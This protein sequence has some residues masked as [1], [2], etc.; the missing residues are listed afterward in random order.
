MTNIFNQLLTPHF[1]V[2]NITYCDS[3]TPFQLSFQ[4]LSTPIMR[5]IIDFHN[6]LMLFIVF[7]VFFV[8]YLLLYCFNKYGEG[9]NSKPADPFTQSTVLE[10]IWTV[11]P[12]LILVVVAT[13]SFALLY[14]MD[15]MIDPSLTV[16][17]IGHQWY[18]SYEYSNSYSDPV[19][20]EEKYVSL[21]FDSFM[22]PFEELFIAPLSDRL[23]DNSKQFRNLEV[24][25]KLF[26]PAHT[27]IRLLV[28]SADVLHSWTIPS[29]GIK[30][31]G[32][33][34]WIKSSPTSFI[35]VW[36]LFWS[37][38]RNLRYKPWFYAHTLY[39]R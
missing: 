8:T 38:F 10:V 23:D 29:F 22:V 39:V 37:M 17:I 14:S 28:S 5:G 25:K 2:R 33:S 34:W 16:K 13:P 9:S 36:Y 6:H 32:L 26:L 3:P 11:I 24:D 18:W 27:Q 15:E 35:P 21:N 12:A 31:D 20:A 30:V 7:I 19:S 4:D 1:S